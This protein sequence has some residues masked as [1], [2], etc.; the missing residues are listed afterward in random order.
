MPPTETRCLNLVPPYGHGEQ[1]VPSSLRKTGGK[2]PG[3]IISTIFTLGM[4]N[5]RVKNSQSRQLRIDF[6][7]ENE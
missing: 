1:I 2:R 6:F 7:V 4:E 5:G 3:S